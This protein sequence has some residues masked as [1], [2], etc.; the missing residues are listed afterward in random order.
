MG[1]KTHEDLLSEL[2]EKERQIQRLKS[3]IQMHVAR[4]SHT[5]VRLLSQLDA[6]DAL[7]AT[8]ERELVA[9][10]RANERLSSKLRRYYDY[11]KEARVQWD[12]MRETVALVLE[13]AELANDY[14]LWPHSQICLTSPLEPLST[15]SLAHQASLNNNDL[16][17]TYAQAIIISLR[18]ELESERQ[19]HEQTRERA[20]FDILSLNARLANR[21]AELEAHI[22]YLGHKDPQVQAGST[23]SH[24]AG[25]GHP[26]TDKLPAA[27]R[28]S[29]SAPISQRDAIN[30]L[31][32]SAARNR[33]LEAEVRGLIGRLEHARSAANVPQ[34]PDIHVSEQNT[35]SKADEQH[36][37]SDRR[38]NQCLGTD[39]SVPDPPKPEPSEDV[40]APDAAP[41][42]VE[43]EEIN[44]IDLHKPEPPPRILHP[45]PP[46]L[47][48]RGVPVS[49]TS[50]HFSSSPLFDSNES[51]TLP[52][53]QSCSD[54]IDLLAHEIDNFKT[55]REALRIMLARERRVDQDR[56]ICHAEKS[57]SGGENATHSRECLQLTTMINDLRCELN[58]VQEGREFQEEKLRSE[59]A[60][61]RQLLSTLSIDRSPNIPMDTTTQS[62]TYSAVQNALHAV[63][64][65]PEDTRI[66]VTPTDI[67]SDDGEERSM[68]LATPLQ[69]TILSVREDSQ[70]AQS[71]RSSESPLI[72]LPN[73]RSPTSDFPTLMLP[74]S[75]SSSSPPLLDSPSCRLQAPNSDIPVDAG[76]IQRMEVIERELLLARQELQQRDS[77]LFEL[78]QI[79]EH[80][81][82]LIYSSDAGDGGN[83]DGG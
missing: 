61:L 50:R 62:S 3:Q 8:H 45:L 2:E 33:S 24:A 75:S 6:M 12:D 25:S 42:A 63:E 18:T 20:E 53:L 74:L 65:T 48:T 66:L 5:Q 55:E 26:E 60:G 10:I 39:T 9:E 71:S 31:E 52:P 29:V 14:S 81:R 49:S 19:A 44:A 23:S 15:Y 51:H 59:I 11:I 34:F 46:L 38:P 73:S 16:L 57:A 56:S 79:V 68:E 72:S 69:P 78:R 35:L 4:T 7:R 13:K 28:R 76:A 27:F 80:L 82:I 54:E 58:M 37:L 83:N 32:I 43:L 40:S 67:L 47:D 30:I 77:E 22:A 17:R 41:P 70:Q 64:P 1:V 21:E 36:G